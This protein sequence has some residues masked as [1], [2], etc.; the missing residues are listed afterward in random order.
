MRPRPQLGIEIY[1]PEDNAGERGLRITVPVDLLRA[2]A[3]DG[4]GQVFV[5][6]RQ[7]LQALNLRQLVLAA[8]QAPRGALGLKAG[9]SAHG[10]PKL[11]G[12]VEVH[13]DANWWDRRDA[14][15]ASRRQEAVGVAT[16]K[17]AASLVGGL[18]RE[19]ENAAVLQA[20]LEELFD[21]GREA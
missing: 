12:E 4:H 18:G 9:T 17:L 16:R 10:E 8:D 6:D 21:A 2:L 13:P 14:R 20:A 5:A 7:T 11:T 19:E 3:A 1:N 15:V